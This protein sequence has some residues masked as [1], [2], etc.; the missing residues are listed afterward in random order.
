MLEVWDISYNDMVEKLNLL[1]GVHDVKTLD[2]TLQ[3]HADSGMRAEIAKA[4]SKS[5]G[6]ISRLEEEWMDLQSVFL[7][8]IDS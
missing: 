7:K 4:V 2:G 8:L 3:V 6:T 5:G 1:D